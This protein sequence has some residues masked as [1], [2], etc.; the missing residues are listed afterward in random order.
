MTR[1]WKQAAT[2][3]SDLRTKPSQG[4][5]LEELEKE[6]LKAEGSWALGAKQARGGTKCLVDSRRLRSGPAWSL[7]ATEGVR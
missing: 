4:G 3:P 7:R 1:A 5:L 2:L 6:R